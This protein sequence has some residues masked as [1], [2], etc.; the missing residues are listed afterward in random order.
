MI[1]RFVADFSFSPGVFFQKKVWVSLDITVRFSHSW[2]LPPETHHSVNYSFEYL[3]L[4]GWEIKMKTNI[5]MKT[6]GM[7]WDTFQRYCEDL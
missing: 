2:R 1:A 3:T 6:D 7:I 4:E 5:K